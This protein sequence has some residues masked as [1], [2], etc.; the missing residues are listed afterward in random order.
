MGR[1][2]TAGGERNT[3]CRRLLQR[4]GRRDRERQVDSCEGAGKDRMDFGMKGII[5]III[6]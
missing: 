6:M 2:D 3:E 4:A 5:I 1:T